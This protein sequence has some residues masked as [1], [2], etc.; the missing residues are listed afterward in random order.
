MTQSLHFSKYHGAG[1]DFIIVDAQDLNSIDLTESQIALWCHRR[2]GIGADGFMVYERSTDSKVAFTMRYYNA[3]GK[4]GSM[5]GNGGRCI[6]R[7]AYERKGAPSSMR[8]SF[9][10]DV[11]SAE[12]HAVDNI[13]LNMLPVHTIKIQED[14][15]CYCNT[16]SPHHIEWVDSGLQELDVFQSGK[17]MRDRYGPEGCNI[18]FVE[19]INDS[20]LAVRTYERGVEDE[21]LA[22]GTG[23]TAAVLSAHHMGKIR[24]TSVKVNAL[25][26]LLEVAFKLAELG[27]E[28]IVLRG[29]AEHVFEGNILA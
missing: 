27:Y 22:C 11:Y 12:V 7:Y 25:G 18:N 4:Q 29:P 5:C 24:A 15:S 26:G 23:V 6:V 16:G 14:Q 8:F 21:T 2:Y 20:E 10:E 28:D 13:S 19:I 9:G 17:V 3:D 1:N